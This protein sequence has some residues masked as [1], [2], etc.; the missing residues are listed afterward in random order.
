MPDLI[1]NIKFK[2]DPSAKKIG[3]IIDK[4][5]IADINLAAEATENLSDEIVDTA[6]ASD[7]ATDTIVKNSKKVK[8]ATASTQKSLS[9]ANQVL[10]SFSDGVQ[11]ASQF[12][13][14]GT[15]NFATG[16]RAI[17]NNIGF[18]SELMGNLTTKTGG[19]TNAIKALGKSFLGPGGILLLINGAITAVTILS[20]K[21]G[22]NKEKVDESKEALEGFNKVLEK[23]IALL[24]QQQFFELGVKGL[25]TELK[26][27]REILAI[28]N[29][30]RLA[31]IQSLQEEKAASDAELENFQYLAKHIPAYHDDLIEAREKNKKIEEELNTLTKEAEE[32][33]VKILELN[34][35]QKEEQEAIAAN[36][37][38]YGRNIN[39]IIEALRRA[40]P[41]LEPEIVLAD[42][43]E[44]IVANIQSFFDELIARESVKINVPID[45][46]IDEELPT[47]GE[48][49]APSG[50]DPFESFLDLGPAAGTLA[51]DLEVLNE[52]NQK[53]LDAQTNA[54][55]IAIASRI[56][57]KEKEI[58]AKRALLKQNNE[59][60]EASNE[61]SKSQLKAVA[62]TAS[63]I[64]PSLFD[65]QKASAIASALVNAGSAIV[66]QYAD[67]PLAAA[68]PA[69]IATAAATK[70][71]IDE[72]KKTKFGDRGNVSAGGGGGGGTSG[73]SPI[74][75]SDVSQ[76]M[77]SISFLPNAATSG[78][79]PPTIDVKIDRAG[80]A[81]AV[82]KG[83]REIGNKQVRV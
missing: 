38:L 12:M 2:I 73:I 62:Q 64:L 18:T 76:P 77:Q 36:T 24:N 30:Q 45:I 81:V 78:Q 28:T 71:Q 83:G 8:Q 34:K 3:D 23:Q 7:N 57:A 14:G 58:E 13:A 33:N 16:M 66:R 31:R 19:F 32:A 56:R 52:L 4:R 42:N 70:K 53:F 72:I 6:I 21:F 20:Q 49:L 65:D 11:D 1:Y 44:E 60:E 67:L 63:S 48:L 17:G 37:E 5:A 61:I 68:I 40:E 74:S 47:V 80:L 46:V 26:T 27:R 10:F 35:E 55:R 43:E 75:S 29:N 22:K 59:N 79:A 50:Q 39:N 41:V 69:S 54:E 25:E 82:G 51:F 9:T 15:F